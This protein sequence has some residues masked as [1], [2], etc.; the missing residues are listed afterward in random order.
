M[1]LCL[2][3][4]LRILFSHHQFLR[5]CF[6][7]AGIFLS[8]LLGVAMLS[9]PVKAEEIQIPPEEETKNETE[10]ERKEEVSVS[11]SVSL[12]DFTAQWNDD[13]G[14][15]LFT[16]TLSVKEA[17]LLEVS[18]ILPALSRENITLG[19][20]TVSGYEAEGLGAAEHWEFEVK[21]EEQRK[22]VFTLFTEEVPGV[23]PHET[24]VTLILKIHA[25]PDE[26][27]KRYRAAHP[28]EE[29]V[30]SQEGIVVI[31]TEQGELRAAAKTMMSSPKRGQGSSDLFL[32]KVWNDAGLERKRPASITFDLYR[33]EEDGSLV[34]MPEEYTKTVEVT[35]EEQNVQWTNLPAG[36]FVIR[37]Q[38]VEGYSAE[39][40]IEEYKDGELHVFVNTIENSTILHLS[41]QYTNSDGIPVRKDAEVSFLLETW[42]QATGETDFQKI[43]EE[44]IFLHT[45]NGTIEWDSDP[46]P[47]AS[48]AGEYFYK[49]TE[50]GTDRYEVIYSLDGEVFTET[51]WEE[52]TNGLM[53]GGTLTVTN[54]EKVS[55]YRLPSTGGKGTEKYRLFLF[56][57]SL[58]VLALQKAVFPGKDHR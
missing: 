57:G 23:L 41:K 13:A 27:W 40:Q 1:Y 7:G 52:E 15:T 47:L 8:L 16:V 10:G 54:R 38:P 51:E 18:L 3:R 44:T 37:E 20:D 21:E 53:R 25:S 35:S 24:P 32:K 39:E 56:L 43:Q 12:T 33:R 34:K 31:K 22:A 55:S 29:E 5:S 45:E 19:G 26:N 46:L 50:C 49:L 42:Q 36:S 30:L 28:A 2:S 58:S 4:R 9:L 11:S 14:E 6:F 17:E 48:S